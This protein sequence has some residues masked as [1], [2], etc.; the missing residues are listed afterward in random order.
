M[1]SPKFQPDVRISVTI[2]RCEFSGRTL[3][4]AAHLSWI[5][6]PLSNEQ[7]GDRGARI[8]MGK[9]RGITFSATVNLSSRGRLKN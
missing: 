1:L 3:A 4:G 2:F 8:E 6:G 5:A 9:S 7:E